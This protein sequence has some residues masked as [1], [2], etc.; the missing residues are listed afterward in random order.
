V[1]FN[2]L[3]SLKIIFMKNLYSAIIAFV[4]CFLLL[5]SCGGDGADSA[6]SDK[7]K[8][9]CEC[10]ALVTE[11][12]DE[13]K[14]LSK[15][16]MMKDGKP[17]TGTCALLSKDRDAIVTFLAEYSQGYPVKKQEWE[18]FNGEKIQITD[19]SF[20]TKNRKSGY[21]MRL[22]TK[23][24]ALDSKNKRQEVIYTS[25]YREYNNDKEVL[26]YLFQHEFLAPKIVREEYN[27]V[28]HSLEQKGGYM[29]TG[30]KE[31]ED[32][33]LDCWR[34]QPIKTVQTEEMGDYDANTGMYNDVVRDLQVVDVFDWDKYFKKDPGAKKYLECLQSKE[35]KKFIVKEAYIDES[36]TVGDVEAKVDEEEE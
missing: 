22:A 2:N 31:F 32:L 17:Y 23:K 24:G 1:G 13:F 16:K 29:I 15:K 6:A 7:P 19:L 9:D 26:N 14:K 12:G 11:K 27:N 28:H 35:I 21:Q 10:G 36:A 33:A 8:Y 4:G 5:T 25:S 30:S 3:V 20:D 34:K 18:L